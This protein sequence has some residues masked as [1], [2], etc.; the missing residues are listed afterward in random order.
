MDPTYTGQLW[1]LAILFIIAAWAVYYFYFKDKETK[2][3]QSNAYLTAL[4]FMAEND[5]RRAIEKFKETVR[6]D[7]L[8]IDAYIKLGDI[9][10]KEGLYSNAIRIHKD[11]TL[12][13]SIDTE[14][15]RKIWYSLAL[16]Y[17]EANK[18]DKAELFFNKLLDDKAWQDRVYPYLLK[19]YERQGKY[20]LA[21][22]LLKK[23]PAA[24]KEKANKRMALLKVME[25]S[26]QVDRGNEKEARILF[27]DAQKNYES[28]SAAYAFL[29]DSYVREERLDD[30]I[31]AWT[32]F[33]N[34]HPQQSYLLF[35]RLERAY[36][37][38]GSFS[39]IE[40]L[41]ESI[42]K[43]DPKNERA[44]VALA[45]IKRKKGDHQTA[46]NLLQEHNLQD[47]DTDLIRIETIHVLFDKGQYEEAAK[48]SLDYIN[49]KPPD[50]KHD[51]SC[52]HCD[53][54]SDKPF[55]K[56]PQCKSLN[57]NI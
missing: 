56:C 50:S 48:Q 49:N 44:L 3:R 4:K 16:D 8:N 34:K 32:E 46:M 21:F 7:T 30:A 31:N 43:K 55:W 51:F 57:L 18:E 14:E 12:R 24:D 13:G 1:T 38:K 2:S 40:E 23:I 26:Q 53:Y 35:P 11:L 22:E 29:G 25:G 5:S 52:A 27:K 54:I 20:K 47:S 42:L 6:Q 33:C 37:D 10:R 28:C 45:G 41:Y 15:T 9:L 17:W 39:K 19:L 36:Y